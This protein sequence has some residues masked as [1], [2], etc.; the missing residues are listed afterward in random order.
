MNIQS[1]TIFPVGGTG[2]VDVYRLGETVEGHDIT[3]I[4]YEGTIYFI[5]TQLRKGGRNITFIQL[6]LP[7]RSVTTRFK[8]P[9][10]AA[11]T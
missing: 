2:Q 11:D 3:E 10:L 9:V 7:D 1:I 8:M 5:K 6:S 4:T